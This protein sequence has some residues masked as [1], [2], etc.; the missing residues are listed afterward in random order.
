MWLWSTSR[1]IESV[2]EGFGGGKMIYCGG[3]N[4]RGPGKIKPGL[5][6]M[7]K[8]AQVDLKPPRNNDSDS[9]PTFFVLLQKTVQ[10]I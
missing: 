9:N 8:D 5:L 6:S 4:V 1:I 10:C 3:I 2:E 7:C